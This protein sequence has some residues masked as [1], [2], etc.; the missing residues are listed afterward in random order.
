MLSGEPD[1]ALL[2]PYVKRVLELLVHD[3]SLPLVNVNFPEQP[4]GICWT[5]QSVR[6]YDGKVVPGEDPMGRK[7]YWFTVVPIEEAEPG[8][9]RRAVEEGYVSITP[10]RLDLTDEE[11]L[12]TARRQHPL[13]ETSLLDAGF[14]ELSWLMK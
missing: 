11:R 9:D 3:A 2:E 13:A 8:T 4:R 5:R 6:H 1:F 7:H 14:V 12:A 10:L